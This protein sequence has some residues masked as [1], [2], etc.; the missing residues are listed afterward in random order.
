LF[1]SFLFFGHL[2]LRRTVHHPVHWASTHPN[3][4]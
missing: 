1:T 3:S 2:L 4:L